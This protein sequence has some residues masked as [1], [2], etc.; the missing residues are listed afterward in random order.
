MKGTRNNMNFTKRLYNKSKGL[1]DKKASLAQET[2]VYKA[3]EKLVH[4]HRDFTSFGS[5]MA[6][7]P[8][9]SKRSSN[10][11]EYNKP[12]VIHEDAGEDISKC[13]A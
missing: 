2:T 3:T 13:Q 12:S 11:V 5:K 6:T 4:T 10:E 8:S 9:T 1:R 7:T